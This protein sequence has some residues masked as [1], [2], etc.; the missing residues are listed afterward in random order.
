MSKNSSLKKRIFAAIIAGTMVMSLSLTGCNNNGK[1]DQSSKTSQ[2]SE[3]AEPN[4][5]SKFGDNIAVK[6]E[7]YKISLPIMTYLFNYN[8]QSYLSYYGTYM[9]YYGFDSSKSLKEQYYDESNSQTW[10]YYFMSMTKD[11]IQQTLVLAEAAKA[12]G[13][14]LDATDLENIKTSMT[15]LE[16]NASENSMT[17]DE[18]VA[19]SYGDGVSQKDIEECLKLTALAQKYYNKVYD[20]FKYTDDDYEKY[21]QDN[22]TSYQYADFLKYTFTV[23]ADST[24]SSDS[25][26]T[27]ESSEHKE[28][29]EK[30]KAYA[31]AL[32]Q[33]KTE[34]EFKDY[35]K[36][37]LTKNPDLVTSS[38]STSES[39]GEESKMT[40]EEIQTAIDTA[41]DRTL[42]EKYSYEVT[43]DVGKWLFDDSRK[44]LDT[45]TIKNTDGSY[46]AVMLLKPAYRDESALKDVRHILLSADTYG[47]DDAAKAK[48]DEVYN[49]WKKGDATEDSFG[50]LANKYSSDGGSNS[51]G[52]L[53]T[54]VT[55]GQM[56]TEFN[57]WCF[58]KSRKP[59]DT[60]IVK[61]QFGYHIM[62]FVGD[63]GTAWKV[64]VDGALRSKDFNDKYNTLKEDYKVEYD[65]D[66]LKTMEVKT[67]SE[68]SSTEPSTESKADE[69]SKS[70]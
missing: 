49:E 53:Y 24:S 10:F 57:D 13:M 38:T 21:Y 12:D 30:A 47:S 43:S 56:V 46:T 4:T 9:S 14:E 3:N 66:Y 37:Y 26:E 54:N 8:Y 68:E 70:E 55:E 44:S 27:S 62:Y 31:E 2:V 60:D 40:D 61:T 32:A 25:S 58:D 52:G 29:S 42:S 35:V 64:A 23:P 67:T 20:G 22:K 45:T 51:K 18:Y 41:V 36:K 6:S 15:Q 39:S 59:G 11:Y 19:K 5:E 7:N 17:A 16:S 63:S 50:E 65:D 28:A 34:D 1:D 69:S 48:A 33:S